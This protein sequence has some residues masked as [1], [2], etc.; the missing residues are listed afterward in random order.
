MSDAATARVKSEDHASFV[1]LNQRAS[2]GC[3]E[4][5]A[6]LLSNEGSFSGAGH[7]SQH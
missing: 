1:S 5:K 6:E 2:H 4:Q 3:W 7:M